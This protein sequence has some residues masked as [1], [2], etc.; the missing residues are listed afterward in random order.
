MIRNETEEYLLFKTVDQR[1]LR[2]VTEKVK[3]EIRHNETDHVTQTNKLAMAATI[4]VTKEVGVKKDKIG[5]KKEPWW[6]RR[7]ESD[8]AN[9][10]R[11]INRLEREILGETGG[12][13][14]R[15]NKE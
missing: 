4:W 14:K 9:L 11:D 1:K 10:R 7:I 2:G 12:K 5:Q 6:K 13:D 8:I 15:K 3:S